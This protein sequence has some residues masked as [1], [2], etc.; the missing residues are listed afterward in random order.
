[1][2]KEPVTR[3]I[4]HEQLVTLGAGIGPTGQQPRRKSKGHEQHA[5]QPS[6]FAGQDLDFEE[7]ERQQINFRDVCAGLLGDWLGIDSAAVLSPRETL[8]RL[9]D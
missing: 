8:V 7:V 1:M 5:G 9:L 3:A 4:G 6:G 2:T